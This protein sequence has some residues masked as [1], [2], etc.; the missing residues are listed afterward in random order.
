MHDCY[1]L[2]VD[3]SSL[4]T[5]ICITT[6]HLHACF[7]DDLDYAQFMCL[8]AM[9]QSLVTP[10]AMLDDDTCLVHHLLNAW[11]CTNANHIYFSKCLLSLL[12]LKESL[13]GATL[14]S[15]RFKLEDDDY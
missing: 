12:S 2:D 10:Y 8:H 15:A 7:H 4:V 6:S 3:A 1:D 14:E 9:T 13:D 5:H 11:F